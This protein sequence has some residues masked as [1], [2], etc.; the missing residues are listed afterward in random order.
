M[1][2]YVLRQ[3]VDVSLLFLGISLLFPFPSVHALALSWLPLRDLGVWG[4]RCRRRLESRRR[5]AG[6]RVG[7][8]DYEL[9]KNV[10]NHDI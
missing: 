9:K 2:I 3:S 7:L 6:R 10:P 1:Y 4:S 8:V 5:R